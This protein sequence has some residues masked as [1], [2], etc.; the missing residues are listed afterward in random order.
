MRDGARLITST[1]DGTHLVLHAST[2]LIVNARQRLSHLHQCAT[3]PVSPLSY[4]H[5]CVTAPVFPHFIY[6]Q[7]R[8]AHLRFSSMR[9]GAHLF[10]V[11][12]TSMHVGAR[13]VHIYAQ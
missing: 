10:F 11:S 5:L 7:E 6:T 13:L 8:S 1:R 3:V 9:D 12:S 4:P 2:L